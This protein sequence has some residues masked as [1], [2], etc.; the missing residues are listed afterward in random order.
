MPGRRRSASA[1][2]TVRDGALSVEARVACAPGGILLWHT[3]DGD[4]PCL[5]EEP[6]APVAIGP[7]DIVVQA[8]FRGPCVP[9]LILLL[10]KR[11][12]VEHAAGTS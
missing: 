5:P 12:R 1:Q 7:N 4:N 2:R 3:E 9:P 11:A 10:R 8:S 6:D